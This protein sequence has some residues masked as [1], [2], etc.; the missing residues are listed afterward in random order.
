MRRR[1]QQMQGLNIRR[2]EF[3][4]EWNYTML[5]AGRQQSDSIIS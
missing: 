2:D 3:H 4:G 1:L 5:P